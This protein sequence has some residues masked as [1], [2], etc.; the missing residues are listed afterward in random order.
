MSPTSRSKGEV[1]STEAVEREKTELIIIHFLPCHVASLTSTTSSAGVL[2]RRGTVAAGIPVTAG[3]EVEVAVD[4][5]ASISATAEAKIPGAG[6]TTGTGAGKEAATGG[7][8]GARN[9]TAEDAA[10]NGTGTSHEICK[11]KWHV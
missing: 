3:I 7:G 4:T 2:L 6:G 11:R 1:A 8:R 10:R 9:G 5:A